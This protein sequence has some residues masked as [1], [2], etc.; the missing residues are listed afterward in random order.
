M[1]RQLLYLRTGPF[2]TSR[3]TKTRDIER[4]LCELFER[5]AIIARQC[6]LVDWLKE[7]DQNTKY[8]HHKAVWRA[9]KNKIKK[10]KDADGVWKDV[11]M[12]MERLT[13]SYFKELIV[14][15]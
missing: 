11:P 6:S 1:E 15:S 3:L 12:D 10:L 2:S 5:E 13:T 14:Y 8:F 4:K 7:G 9:R